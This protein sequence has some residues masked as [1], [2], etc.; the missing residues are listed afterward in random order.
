[1]SHLMP[2][3][4][5]MAREDLL[6]WR[7]VRCDRWVREYGSEDKSACWLPPTGAPVPFVKWWLG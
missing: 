1:M 7:C 2:S 6:A 3:S 4:A 5:R